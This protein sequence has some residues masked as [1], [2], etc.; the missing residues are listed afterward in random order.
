MSDI[1]CVL[2]LEVFNES[3]SWLIRLGQT[4]N[5]LPLRKK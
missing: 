5:V 1:L 3:G 2:F 4:Y